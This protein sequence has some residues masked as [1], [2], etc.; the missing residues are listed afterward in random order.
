[1]PSP[2]TS[3]A[4]PTITRYHGSGYDGRFSRTP[5]AMAATATMPIAE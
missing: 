2:T 4:C 3:I 5:T 1:M